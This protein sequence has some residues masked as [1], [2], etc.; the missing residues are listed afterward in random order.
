MLQFFS[1]LLCLLA[2]QACSSTSSEQEPS[3]SAPATIQT[4]NAVPQEEVGV[5]VSGNYGSVHLASDEQT[6]TGLYEPYLEEG[7]SA[8]CSFYFYG[9][10]LEKGQTPIIAFFPDISP[11]ASF[12]KLR[13]NGKQL[14]ISFDEAPAEGC[15]PSLTSSEG[16]S[17]ELLEASS[18]RAIRLVRSDG[19]EFFEE[20][21][22]SFLLDHKLMRYDMLRVM[23]EREGWLRAQHQAGERQYSGWVK[24]Q[25]LYPVD[26]F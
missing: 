3:D 6:I 20:P 7:A 10:A 18:W 26:L 23:E 17:M 5:S 22:E 24:S 1:L 8:S 2:L 4:Q 14:T 12:G 15:L 13:I 16:H 11:K 19:S 25:D 9:E 21:N